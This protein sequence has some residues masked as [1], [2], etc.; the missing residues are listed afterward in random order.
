MMDY[1]GV[2]PPTP[3]ERASLRLAAN[4]EGLAELKKRGHAPGGSYHKYPDFEALDEKMMERD[5]RK[6]LAAAKKEIESERKVHKCYICGRRDL[7]R[8]SKWFVLWAVVFVGVW[9]YAPEVHPDAPIFGVLGALAAG[10]AFGAGMHEAVKPD[11][12]SELRG[13]FNKTSHS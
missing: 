3:V 4:A 12:E 9:L 11:D 5:S 8:Y 6:C 1:P 13:K 7:P 10:A 2:I